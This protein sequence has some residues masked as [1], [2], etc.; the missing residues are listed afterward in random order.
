M[1]DINVNSFSLI[2]LFF[3]MFQYVKLPCKN[4]LNKNGFRCNK[5]SHFSTI[6]LNKNTHK[7]IILGIYIFGANSKILLKCQKSRSFWGRCPA[8]ISNMQKKWKNSIGKSYLLQNREN[9]FFLWETRWVEWCFVIK[10]TSGY[11]DPI[12][13]LEKKYGS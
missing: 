12:Y 6:I 13:T 7:I 10:E 1:S 11:D 4:Y 3:Y 5:I 2:F 9:P 8:P